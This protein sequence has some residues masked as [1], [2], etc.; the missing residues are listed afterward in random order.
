MRALKE[1]ASDG[2]VAAFERAAEALGRAR[3]GL[4]A[5]LP[6]RREAVDAALAAVVAGGGALVK[7]PR[8]SG[9]ALVRGL[10]SALGLDCA[11]VELTRPAA[12]EHLSDPRAAR[13]AARHLKRPALAHPLVLL[14]NFWNAAPALRAGVT[15]FEGEP[16]FHL[17]VA[18]DARLELGQAEPFLARV[19]AAGEAVAAVP[20]AMTAEALVEAQG[21]AARLPVG[22]QVLAAALD[23]VRR[24]RP[25]DPGAPEALRA[26]ALGGPTPLAA[27]ALIRLARARALVEGRAAVSLEDARSMAR[28]ALAHRMAW[29]DGAD[30]EAAFA[31]LV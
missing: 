4:R 2:A 26:A 12:F 22:E 29:R 20:R 19:D 17:F 10:G 7:G 15:A 31:A 13:A 24:A 14:E 27:R 30:V 1:D 21:I 16:P 5:A 3:Q 9:R 8:A 28:P 18:E 23:L 11:V 6:G 25:S